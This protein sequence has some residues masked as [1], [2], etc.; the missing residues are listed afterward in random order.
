VVHAL[1][2]VA[3]DLFAPPAPCQVETPVGQG[4]AVN[5]ARLALSEV[6]A[7]G[8]C[9]KVQKFVE[10][11]A[12]TDDVHLDSRGSEAFIASSILGTL[13]EGTCSV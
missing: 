10:P 1:L 5:S 3:K 8:A 7:V 6:D 2:I 12:H 4:K 9:G 13:D 11:D